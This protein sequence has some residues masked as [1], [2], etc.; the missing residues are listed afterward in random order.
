MTPT[1]FAK[2]LTHFLGQYLP[3]RRNVSP[4]TIKAYR[5]TF[6]LLLRY[7]R[8]RRGIAPERLTLEQIDSSLVLDFLK[9]LEQERQCKTSTRNYRLAALHAFFRYVQTEE[10]QRLLQCQH[11]LSIPFKRSAKPVVNYLSPEELKIVLAQPDLNSLEGRRDAV[12]LSL[13][14]DT[15]ARVQEIVDLCVRDIRLQSPAQVKIFGKG[16]KT[17]AVPIM[18]PTAHLLREYLQEQQLNQPERIDN[19]LFFNRYGVRLSRSGVRYILQK[20]VTLAKANH[21]RFRENISPHVLRH[22]KAMHLLQAD[23]PLIII[24]NILG[25]AD[26]VTTEVYA[27]ADLKMK[28][29]ALEKVTDVS[30]TPSL[31][32]WQTNKNLLNWLKSL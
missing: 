20:Y 24:S 31:T 23:V 8:D 15:G 3:A 5:D 22:S 27:K 7:C 16:R 2:A 4:N 1:N 12:L 26:V 9:H 25:H 32:S 17:R 18:E 11:I 30:P 19:P 29:Q 21:P 10:P 13:L 6:S 14:Y 28:R